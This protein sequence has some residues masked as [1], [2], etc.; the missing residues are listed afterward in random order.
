MKTIV[1]GLLKRNWK[2]YTEIVPDVETKTLVPIIRW[3]I[4][5]EDTE[6]NSDW[7]IAYNGLVDIGHEKIL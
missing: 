1:F 4:K 6:N 5:I 7:W 2:V 3:K